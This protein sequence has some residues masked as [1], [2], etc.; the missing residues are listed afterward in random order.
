MS[1]KINRSIDVITAEINSITEHT[2][3]I[4][5]SSAIEVGRRLVEAKAQLQHGEWGKWLAESV[6]Y[7]QSKA[8]SL[9]QMYREYGENSHALGNIGFTQAVALLAVPGEEREQFVK[10]NEVESMSTRELQQAIKEKQELEQ[11]LKD[12]ESKAQKEEEAKKKLSEDHEK[13]KKK[14]KEHGEQL[15]RLRQELEEAK[16]NGDSEE[17]D[18]LQAS[19]DVSKVE[20]ETMRAKVKELEDE[21][22]KK[23]IDV[24]ATVEVIPEELTRELEELR[25]KVIKQNNKPV[26]KF[27]VC[28]DSVVEG[29]K[30]LLQAM[31]EVTNEEDHEKCKKAVSGLIDKMSERL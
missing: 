11:K 25:L 18:K 26:I 19:F 14:A 15:K 10:E 4:V 6:N 23:P 7:S 16:A 29:F 3:N 1:Q 31:N 12:S 22:S 30:N 28:F 24:P 2:R 8:N 17:E 27:G 21:L 5:L 9:M 13:L 20:L